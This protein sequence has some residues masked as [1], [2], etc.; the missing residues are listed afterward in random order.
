LEGALQFP[1]TPPDGLDIHAGDLPEEA[2]AAVADLHGFQG[3]VPAALLLVEAAEEEVH[4]MVKESI[5]MFGLMKTRGA[6]TLVDD[7][8]RHR[9]GSPS[10]DASQRETVSKHM[11]N[12][13]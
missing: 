6:L 7:R 12:A 8:L 13:E 10:R 1:T 4:P 2:V 3:D 11:E 5:G 9:C